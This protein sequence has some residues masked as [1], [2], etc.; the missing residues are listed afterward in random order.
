[1]VENVIIDITK[2]GFK[3]FRC[4]NEWIPQDIKDRPV[5]CPKCKSPYWNK[6]RKNKKVKQ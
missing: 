1:M 2:K 4:R 3:C 6:P 5:T